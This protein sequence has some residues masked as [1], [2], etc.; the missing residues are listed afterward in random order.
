MINSVSV[1]I[2]KTDSF[3]DINEQFGGTWIPEEK[4]IN[5]TG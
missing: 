5:L 3:K 1:I 4:L 2:V